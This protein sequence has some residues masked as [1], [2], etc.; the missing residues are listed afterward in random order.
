[1][2]AKQVEATVVSLKNRAAAALVEANTAADPTI[3][4]LLMRAVASAY[5]LSIVLGALAAAF[6]L[7]VIAALL[8]MP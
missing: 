3:D 2:E 1:M 4:K 8:V 7:G 6:A 5:T